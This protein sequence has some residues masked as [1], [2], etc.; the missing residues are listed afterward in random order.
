M[1][2]RFFITKADTET[3]WWN[4]YLAGDIFLESLIP[5][6]KKLYLSEEYI[7]D[8]KSFWKLVSATQRD[9]CFCKIYYFLN[10]MMFCSTNCDLS[11]HMELPEKVIKRVLL[12]EKSRHFR[13]II[14]LY[15]FC[16][17]ERFS[18]YNWQQMTGEKEK[19]K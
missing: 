4:I 7:K 1:E 10:K 6:W 17:K 8:I 15:C 12:E 13:K 2:I 18:L 11:G 14:S 9:S 16:Y 19:I 3:F 5:F